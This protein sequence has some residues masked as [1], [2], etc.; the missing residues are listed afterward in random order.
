[1]VQ[2]CVNVPSRS[3]TVRRYTT[4][5]LYAVPTMSAD[6]SVEAG[7]PASEIVRVANALDGAA[8]RVEGVFG[9]PFSERPRVLLFATPASF[10]KGA[11]EIF[12]YPR[13]T[14]LL[15]ANSYGG[16]VDQAKLTIAVDWHAVGSDLSGLI[17]HELVHVMIRDIAGRDAALP[18][19]FEEGFATVIQREDALAA[20]TDALVARSLQANGVVSLEQLQTLPDWHRTFARVGRAQYTVAALAVRAME[21]REG[22]SG[23]VDA[24]V[25]VGGGASF[26]DAYAALET[27][28]LTAFVASFDAVTEDSAKIVVTASSNGSADQGWTLNSF[29]PNSVVRVH[30]TG[31]SN[32]YDL[33]FTVTADNTGMFRGR[34]GSTAAAGAYTIAAESGALHARAEIVNTR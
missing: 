23:L 21:A 10:A 8:L 14:A 2:F 12:N 5:P 32:G 22:Q 27:G 4:V 29:R 13:E 7:I 25:A 18:A 6:L 3:S 16:I 28:P 20:D 11:Q 34:F 31:S 1:V 30:I 17:A 9:R 33:A 24:L 19:W 15:A 26:E